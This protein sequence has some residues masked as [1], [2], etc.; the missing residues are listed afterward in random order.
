MFYRIFVFI[1]CDLH[2][3]LLF[4]RSV[5]LLLKAKK[6]KE[7]LFDYCAQKEYKRF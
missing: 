5:I 6:E 4:F 3:F 2:D 7:K 1:L